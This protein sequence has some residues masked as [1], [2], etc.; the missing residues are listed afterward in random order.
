MTGT[1]PELFDDLGDRAMR[2][3][4]SEDGGNSKVEVVQ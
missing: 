2:V 4:V 1:G 3:H